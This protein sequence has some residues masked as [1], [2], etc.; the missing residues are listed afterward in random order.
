MNTKSWT[1]EEL[2]ELYDNA[3]QQLG[4]MQ[5]EA[6][7]ET[8][9]FGDSGPGSAIEIRE[10]AEYVGSLLSQ[11]AKLSTGEPNATS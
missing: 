3:V 1:K 7:N 8:A 2:I 6:A 9:Q 4:E 10:Q 5:A 11:L